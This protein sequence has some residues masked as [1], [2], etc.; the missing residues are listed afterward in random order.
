MIQRDDNINSE[1]TTDKFKQT[2]LFLILQEYNKFISNGKNEIIPNK[3][4]NNNNDWIGDNVEVNIVSKFLKEYTISN[5]TENYIE[6]REICAWLKDNNQLITITK[7][8]IDLKKY[9][10]IKKYDKVEVKQ[11]KINKKCVNVWIGIKENSEY[12]NGDNSDD[13]FV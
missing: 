12:D 5:N 4:K 11:K 8:A 3:V 9:C 10:K 7:F 1:I 13:E 6:S 2:F